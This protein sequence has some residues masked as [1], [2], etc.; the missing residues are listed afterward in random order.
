[1]KLFIN[2]FCGDVSFLEDISNLEIPENSTVE[3]LLNICYEKCDKQV[4][5]GE[6]MEGTMVMVNS[7]LSHL[8]TPLTDQDKIHLFRTIDGG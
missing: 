8:K 4:S 5:H 7:S 2:V 3:D 1:M 6:F